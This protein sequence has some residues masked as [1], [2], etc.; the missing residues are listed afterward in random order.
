MSS[1]DKTNHYLKSMPAETEAINIFRIRGNY[2]LGY[3]SP[4]EK[5]FFVREMEK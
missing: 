5:T 4:K 1:I 2:Y 3:Y